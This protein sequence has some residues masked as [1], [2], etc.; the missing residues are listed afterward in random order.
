M[1]PT[2]TV[3]FSLICLI[4]YSTQTFQFLSAFLIHHKGNKE[5]VQQTILLTITST[6]IALTTTLTN[7]DSKRQDKSSTLTIYKPLLDT[8][9]DLALTNLTIILSL[10]IVLV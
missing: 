8:T 7:F 10:Y 3:N 1:R 5:S 6:D 2:T 4:L 9:F